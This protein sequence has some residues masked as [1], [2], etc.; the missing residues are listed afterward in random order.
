MYIC[1]SIT[2]EPILHWFMMCVYMYACK[3]SMFMYV[4]MAIWGTY[5]RTP[6][7]NVYDVFFVCFFASNVRVHICTLSLTQKHTASTYTH[8]QFTYTRQVAENI[9][10]FL[11]TPWLTKIK[12]SVTHKHTTTHT[13][14]HALRT[15]EVS[16]IAFLVHVSWVM[17]IKQHLTHKH[18][19]THIH[20]RNE[21]APG[22]L[23]C[24]FVCAS[25][26][27]KMK[28]PLTHKHTATHIHTR[29]AH[30]PGT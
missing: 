21:H 9:R 26:I 18:T 25:W 13:H 28:Q 5:R 10:L 15:H 23:Y 12:L 11:N 4:C 30:A 22:T 17:N 19:A 20:T 1:K 29:N 6:A 16:C 14:I 3:F 2:K 27:M 8:T 7:S 24:S